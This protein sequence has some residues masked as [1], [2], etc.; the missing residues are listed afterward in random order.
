MDFTSVRP[1][2]PFDMFFQDHTDRGLNLDGRLIVGSE[3]NPN[4]LIG[5]DHCL[6]KRGGQSATCPCLRQQHLVTGTRSVG[7]WRAESLADPE[8]GAARICKA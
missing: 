3:F 6:V 5:M 2:T 4:C 8:G 7:N 1:R